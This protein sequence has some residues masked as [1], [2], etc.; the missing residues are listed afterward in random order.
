MSSARA[1]PVPTISPT[2]A[3]KRCV[4]LL[5]SNRSAASRTKTQPTQG[6]RKPTS[7]ISPCG[8]AGRAEQLALGKEIVTRL[9]R[10]SASHRKIICVPCRASSPATT[11][12]RR[13]WPN[14]KSPP[15]ACPQRRFGPRLRRSVASRMINSA[16][17][18][19]PPANAGF[20]GRNLLE[21]K[22][23]TREPV[24]RKDHAQT[25]GCDHDRFGP[26]GS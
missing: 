25:R 18:A 11:V 22:P 7:A 24:F 23:E 19:S 9:L 1:K 17:E 12:L 16:A 20:C 8:R 14:S 15:G 26:I 4:R 6:R 3:A 21:H 13:P 10:L 2:S 5:S